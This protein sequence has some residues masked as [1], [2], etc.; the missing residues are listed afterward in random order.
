VL[1]LIRRIELAQFHLAVRVDAKF[2]AVIH[3]LGFRA[4][5][6][7]ARSC[8]VAL[9]ATIL[10]ASAIHDFTPRS[11]RQAVTVCGE[12]GV[13]RRAAGRGFAEMSR[14]RVRGR[15]DCPK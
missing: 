6:P 9:R 10:L 1:V 2:L 8:C 5:Q 4:D 14:R 12:L 3:S 7:L 13:Q 11:V 15:P